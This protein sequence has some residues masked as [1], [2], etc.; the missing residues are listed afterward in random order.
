MDGRVADYGVA[1]QH[2]QARPGEGDALRLPAELH[3]HLVRSAEH[4]GTCG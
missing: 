3:A 1:A 4:D 2:E